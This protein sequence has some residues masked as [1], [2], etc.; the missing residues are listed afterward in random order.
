MTRISCSAAALIAACSIVSTASASVVWT[1]S[2]G[3][4]AAEIEFAVTG[5]N[6]EVTLSNTSPNDVLVPVDVLTGVFFDIAGAPL[7]LTRQSAKVAPGSTVLFGTTD[8]GNV[9]GGEWAYKGGLSGGPHGAKYGLS[10]SGLGL[11]GPG[12]IFPGSNLE[13]P[14]SPGGLEYGIT[15]IGDNPAT[16][17][18]PVTGSNALIKHS[19]VFVLGGVGESFDLNRIGNV[20]FQYGTALSEPNT[21]GTPAPGAAALLGLGSLLIA[22]R[23]R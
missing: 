22:R 9:V 2:S 18:T 4:R 21:P 5:G 1:G 12:D 6:L 19:V 10:S 8:P 11:F 14:A 7:T 17:N 16:G 15:S 3:S 23:R 20:S 13:G